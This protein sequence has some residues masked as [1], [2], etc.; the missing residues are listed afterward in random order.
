VGHGRRGH[1][2]SRK[3][4]A[5]FKLDTRPVSKATPIRPVFN[6]PIGKD[7]LPRTKPFY[8]GLLKNI[9]NLVDTPRAQRT[10]PSVSKRVVGA[11]PYS[12]ITAKQPSIS[13]TSVQ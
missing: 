6:V 11:S 9:P 2:R 5:C 12:S 1:A 8:Q 3:L 13:P 4:G 10:M 7:S